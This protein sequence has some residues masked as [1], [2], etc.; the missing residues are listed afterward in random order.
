MTQ[1]I[2]ITKEIAKQLLPRFNQ[3]CGSLDESAGFVTKNCSADF[4]D[5]FRAKVAN[6]MTVV[7]W[8]ILEQM[9]YTQYPE[10]RPYKLGETE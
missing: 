7:G 3:A 8:D 1:N 2:G 9:I 10:L 4:A 6:A 5:E